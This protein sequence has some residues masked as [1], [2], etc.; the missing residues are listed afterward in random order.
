MA[1]SDALAK[2]EELFRN[3]NE[4]IEEVSAGVPRDQPLLDFL[5]E[6]DRD[7]CEEKVQ[8]A[9]AEYEAVRARPTQFIVLPGHEDRRVERV[10]ST[11]DRFTIVEKQGQ[12]AADAEQT[13]P[14]SAGDP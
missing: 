2:N 12:A 3:V 14:R 8:A 11:N 13:D 4:R 10:V 6:C 9:R 1:L 7:D 5:C